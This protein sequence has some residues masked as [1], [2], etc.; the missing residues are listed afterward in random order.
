[1]SREKATRSARAFER[2]NH[3][4]LK[5][6]VLGSMPD[7][8]ALGSVDENERLFVDAGAIL[9][10]YD[11]EAL[12]LLLENSNSLRQNIDAYVTNIDAFGH[13]FE[14]VIDLDA[15]DAD[16]RI[17]NAIYVE[18]LA[19]RE[20]SRDDPVVQAKPL[21]PKAEE[22]TARKT[23]V[24]A[25]TRAERS[26]LERFFDFCCVDHSF[27]T[28][29][30]RTRQDLETLGNAYWEVLRDATGEIVQFVYI[31]GFTVRLLPIEPEPVR[32]D[33]KVK[34][35]DLA[36]DDVSVPRRFRRFVQVFDSRTVYFKEFGDSRLL[37]RKTGRLC[38]TDDEL[39]DGDQDEGPATEIL[40]FKLH[41]PRSV[42]GT[43]R[44]IGNLLAVLGSRQAEEINYLY[45]ENK[46][47]PPLALLVSGGRLSKSSIPRIEDFIENHLRGKRNFHKILVI[48][49]EPAQGQSDFAH[50][51]RM[52]IELK[53]LTAAQQQD[54]L[55][56]SYDERN[57]DKVGQAF[58]LPRLLRGDI[59]D[60]N[61]S[62]AD[63]ALH[64][65]EQQVFQPERDEFDF[66]I[67][68]KILADMGIRFWRFRS[69]A[70]LTRDPAAM[71]DMVVALVKAGV[72]TPEEG[73][74]LAGDVFNRDF[75][76]IDAEWVR[77]P[78]SLT[79]AGFAAAAAPESA[80]V[81]PTQRETGP[82]TEARLPGEAKRLIA[83][84]DTL[85]RA[86][87]VR[88]AAEKRAELER[89]VL[90][91]PRAEFETWFEAGDAG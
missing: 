62:T 73:R 47:V 8:N 18:R 49:A 67:N 6:H 88:E 20:A 7:S 24:A 71:T 70:P 10:P 66:L 58:R 74:H 28:L 51:G 85:H 68:R 48:E 75:K 52:R 22:V 82:A 11:P 69:N 5:A 38:A 27:V 64:F 39:R 87:L 54:E 42:Y 32:V 53:P 56:Q 45:F 4:I 35:S 15:D 59:R 77:Q 65:A 26:E 46:S 61:R 41:N 30:R 31:P 63:A 23:E 1:M 34:V 33:M 16:Q 55:F 37:S 84:R 14:P 21:M 50:S 72:L 9:P 60:F 12:C 81:G 90:R 80:M 2:A 17:A 25:A 3:P 44:W 79:L 76:K 91:V 43:P 86:A 89:E 29:R 78:I 57:V 40:H 83:L 36:F 19:A 13:R